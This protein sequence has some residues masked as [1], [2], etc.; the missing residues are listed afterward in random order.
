MKKEVSLNPE[1]ME[2]FKHKLGSWS[3]IFL[4]KT[5]RDDEIIAYSIFFRA[6]THDLEGK[7][8]MFPRELVRICR[9][10]VY[11]PDSA[12]CGY[13]E[14]KGLVFDSMPS[15]ADAFL[16]KWFADEV[17]KIITLPQPQS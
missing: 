10:I 9:R 17:R 8:G 5:E 2:N 11:G 12:F 6:L 4:S 16:P 14:T 15:I 13:D 3:K 1:E 7:R